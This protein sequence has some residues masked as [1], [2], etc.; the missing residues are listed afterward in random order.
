[1]AAD[2]HI[3]VFADGELTEDDFRTFFGNSLG[4]KWFNPTASTWD[5]TEELYAKFD[6]T[7][8]IWIGE[9]SWL[10]AALF[11]DPDKFIPNPVMQVAEIIGEELPVVD[12]ELIEKVGN[13]LK[14][15]NQTTAYATSTASEVV[16]FLQKHKG[17][18]AFKISW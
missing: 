13:A 3:H 12:D 15:E 11:D 4:S 14:T 16:E 9:V 7:P 8:N 17:K 5:K 2:L 10:K 6:A 18:H 1:M